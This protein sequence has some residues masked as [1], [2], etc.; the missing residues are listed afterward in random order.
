MIAGLDN[1]EAPSDKEEPVGLAVLDVGNTSMHVGVWTDRSVVDVSHLESGNWMELRQALE[2]LRSNPQHARLVAAVVA[3]V[4]PDALDAVEAAVYDALD[5]RVQV[6]GRDVPL[7]LKVALNRPEA[8]G[9][10]RVCSAAAAYEKV[11]G[12]CTVVDFGTAVTIDLVDESGVF[13]G[14]AILPGLRLQALALGNHTAALPVVAMEFPHHAVGK[15]TAEAIQSGICHGLVGAVRNLVEEYASGLNRWP[16]V[17]AT[18]GDAKMMIEHCDFIDAAVTDLC[19]RG[20]GVAYVKHLG[21]QAGE[22]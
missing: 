1:S 18:G 5:L 4:V 3:C 21:A 17:V 11:Q 19:L 20:V 10:D 15:D 16:Y 14:G 12:M 2:G 22:D 13:A 6:V 7:P 8:V 9:A